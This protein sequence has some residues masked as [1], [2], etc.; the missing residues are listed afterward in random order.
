MYSNQIIFANRVK[1]FFYMALIT[2]IIGGAGYYI[3][4]MLGYGLMGTG[5]F[6]VFAGLLDFVAYFFSDTIV[7]KSTGAVPIKEEEMPE[8]YAMVRDMC[9]RNDIKM[10]RLYMI[11]TNAMNAFATGRNQDK[12]VVAVTRG[13]LAKLT[14][15]EVSG[16]VG[17]EL[18]HIANGDMLLMSVISILIGFLSM[19]AHVFR[20]NS[21]MGRMR[22]KDESGISSLIG[23]L[24]MIAA[25]IVATLIK[26]AISRSRE[27][28]AD[29]K[30]AQICGNPQYLAN[31]LEKIRNDGLSM[32]NANEATA[33]LYFSNP[34]SGGIFANL[35]STHPNINDRINKLEKMENF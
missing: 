20:Y 9:S 12:A 22:E 13:L 16:V 27:Y 17:H 2:A 32:P 19:L 30:G 34:F 6:L 21:I 8:Y 35:L 26:L 29:A 23:I 25:P 3:S 33:H 4:D 7:I 28:M 15:Q 5:I 1:V 14:P 10:P 11:N 18:S 24:L 31:A